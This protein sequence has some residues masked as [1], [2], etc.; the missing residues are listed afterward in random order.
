MRREHKFRLN[1]YECTDKATMDFVSASD[2][3]VLTSIEMTC[4]WYKNYTGVLDDYE[5]QSK[6]T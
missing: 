6:R 5:C 4:S 2:G 1:R 3:S